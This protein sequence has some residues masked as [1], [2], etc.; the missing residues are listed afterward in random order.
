[1]HPETDLSLPYDI[2]NLRN[3]SL[4]VSGDVFRWI[5]DY[6]HPLVLRRVCS[7][8][9]DIST[10]DHLL[11]WLDACSRRCLCSNVTG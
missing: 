4:A 11:T 8:P 3:Y 1:M 7:L 9:K 6:A 10:R 2:S 5:V